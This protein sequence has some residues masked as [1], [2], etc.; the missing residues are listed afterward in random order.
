MID[1]PAIASIW[2]PTAKTLPDGVLAVYR[3]LSVE[4]KKLAD[5][6]AEYDDAIKTYMLSHN[7]NTVS[8]GNMTVTMVPEH[9]SHHFDAKA[10]KEKEP[11]TYNRYDKPTLVKAT[12]RKT[13]AP[14]D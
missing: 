6:Q 5:L 11:E 9:P 12:I 10:L 1:Y 4:A 3:E 13:Y 14:L 2:E 7:L 8:S